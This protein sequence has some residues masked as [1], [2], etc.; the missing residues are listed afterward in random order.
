MN[1]SLPLPDP[2]DWSP[3]PKVAPDE[4]GSIVV[5]YFF[6]KL[7]DVSVQLIS[8]QW[9]EMAALNFPVNPME[10]EKPGP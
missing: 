6:H 2:N 9:K 1:R 5:K 3:F 7:C 8:P 10:N 4:K